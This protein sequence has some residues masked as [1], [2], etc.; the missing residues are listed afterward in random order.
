MILS[1]LCLVAALAPQAQAPTPSL[2]FVVSILN[3]TEGDDVVMRFVLSGPPS[4]YSATRE[5][6]DILVRIAAQPLTAL[7][8]PAP[9][10]PIRALALGAEP[11]FTLRLTLAEDR[12][13]EIVRDSSSLR[14]VFKPRVVAAVTP[15]PV[16]P[17]VLE[18]IPSPT[19]TPSRTPNR[20]EDP[21]AVDTADLYRRLFPSTD[22]PTTLGTRRTDIGESENWYSNF[23]WLGIQ[24]RPWVSVSYVD[25]KTTQVQTNTVSADTYWVIQPNLGLG[26]S[27]H[28]GADN[29]NARG[30]QW[31]I[32][33]TP[34]FRRL[35]DL[36]LPRLTSHFFDVGLDQPIASLGSIYGNYHFSKGVLETEEID[37]GREYGIGLNRV[38]DTSLERFRRNSFGVGVRFDFVA[39]TRVDI[40]ATKTNVSY[41]NA[42]E[43]AGAVIGERAF[44]DYDTRTLNASLQR[45]LGESRFLSLLFGVHDTPA[46]KERKQVEGRGYSYGASVEGD[47]AALTTGRLLFGYRTQKSPN[48]GA[49]GQDYKDITYGAQLLREISEDA[50]IGLGADRKLY[51]SA[52]AENGFY[53]ADSLRGDVNTKVPLSVFVR[54]S[55]G[56]QTNSYKASPQTNDGTNL[57]LRHDKIRFWSVGLARSVTE[58]AYLRFDYTVE[59]RNSNLDR[60]DINTRAIT[61]QLGLGFFGKASG[62]AKP[63]W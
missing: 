12:P 23:T 3:E 59:R 25:G 47:I 15:R 56:L 13:Y 53:V 57:V 26:F 33:Y 22:D 4:S 6:D 60:F 38:I 30:G 58:W 39:E 41:G 35:A 55:V 14:L 5:G 10:D 16:T 1:L 63:S 43:D 36:N 50:N 28:L 52:Y 62:Q 42:P 37:P 24:M 32:N 27:P 61:F 18:P 49:G 20:S 9:N 51:L 29:E 48:A 45:G 8:L 54:G 19:P 21:A 11:G 7:S 34:R 2:P 46:Q 31:K 17:A 44:F 40:N